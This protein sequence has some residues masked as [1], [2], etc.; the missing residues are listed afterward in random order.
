MQ[1]EE[2]RFDDE[3][4]AKQMQRDAKGQK[5]QIAGEAAESELEEEALERE[6][7]ERNTGLKEEEKVGAVSRCIYDPLRSS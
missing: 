5:R 1:E 4:A 2:E 6:D 3:E 7:R